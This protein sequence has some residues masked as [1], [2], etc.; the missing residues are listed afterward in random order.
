MYP[1]L[2]QF[3]QF[4]LRSYGVI[5]ILSFLAALW[6]SKKEAAR[7]GLDPA[8][9]DNFALYA[10]LGGILGARIYFIAFSD[11]VYYLKNPWEILAVWRGGL[12]VIGSLIGGFLVAAWYCRKNRIPLLKFADTLAPAAALGQTLGQFACLAN[13]DSV[14]K[15][16]DLPWA[17]T[18]TD[19]RSM[20]PL[21]VPLHPIELYEMGAYFLVFVLVWKTRKRFK[22]EGYSLLT[23][24]AAYGV[25]RFAVEFFRGHPAVFAGGIPAAQVFSTALILASLAGFF[26]L[27]KSRNEKR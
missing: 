20:A 6:L 5:V 22:V 19:P 23:Y 17:I 24:L 3:G 4:E 11:P 26:I 13:G 21:N 27:G 25:A 15:Q 14:G 2:L 7:I 18:Y 10:L 12:G 16:T 8:L 1:I 9:V